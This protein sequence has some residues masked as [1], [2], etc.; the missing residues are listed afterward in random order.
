MII[1]TTKFLGAS[2]V[3]FS[4]SLGFNSNAST[5]SVTLVEDFENGDDF[6]ADEHSEANQ[7]AAAY[8]GTPFAKGNPGSYVKF[9]AP[10]GVF[11]FVGFVTNYRRTKSTSGNLINLEVSDGRFLLSQIPIINDTNLNINTTGFNTA[12]WNIFCAPA[13]FNNPVTI[14][15]NEKGIRFD[16]LM[17]ALS[18]RGFTFYGTTFKV[19]L[20]SSF[21]NQLIGGYRLK[22]QASTLDDAI[23]QAAREAGIDWYTSIES[24]GGQEVMYIKGINRKNQYV[25]SDQSN[26]ISNFISSNTATGVSSWEIGREL[27][28]EPTVTVIVGDRVRSLWDTS[29]GGTFNIF[30]ELGNGIVID[31][32]FVNLDFASTIGW[33]DYPTVEISLNNTVAAPSD[34][35][36]NDEYSNSRV[37]YQKITKSK[38]PK[39]RKGYIAT[40]T[41][42]RAALH[43]KEAW[44]TAV[45]YE[46]WNQKD[47]VAYNIPY[48][49]YN[50][51]DLGFGF[52]APTENE[53]LNFSMN[54]NKLGIY[55]P[56]FNFAEDN[57]FTSTATTS[58]P[59]ADPVAETAKEVAYQA[60]AR[61]AQEYYGKKFICR[62]PA[63]TICQDVG[64]QYEHN[65]KKIP[66]EYDIVDSAPHVT[67][68]TSNSFISFPNSLLN[69]DSAGFRSPNGLFK[70]FARFNANAIN[71]SYKYIR[72]N[73]FNPS[74]SV[75]AFSDVSENANSST[76]T[77]YYSG[78]SVEPYRFD[79]R[80]AIV[81]LNEPLT[82]GP[83][84][85][86]RVVPTSYNTNGEITGFTITTG[87]YTPITSN[88]KTGGFL[89][90]MSRVLG[91][92][93]IVSRTN[94]LGQ[95][96]PAGAGLVENGKEVPVS[97]Q[98]GRVS[99]DHY[100]KLQK[101]AVLY[102]DTVGLAEYR[103]SDLNTGGRG[104]FYIPLQWNYIK[105]GPWVN[106]GGS[107]DNN[108]RPVNIIED[109]KLNPWT[110]GSFS[111]M[112]DAANILAER[113]N[114][115]THTIGYATVT[116]AGF[117]Q[118][119]LG[120]SL[121]QGTSTIANVTNLTDI[122]VSY[123]TDGVKT[124]YKFKTFFGPNGFTKRAELDTISYN[125]YSTTNSQIGASEWQKVY[126]DNLE[127]YIRS[128]GGMRETNLFG[129]PTPDS[130]TKSS[131]AMT[132]TVGG[133]GPA[134]EIITGSKDQLKF[135]LEAN[136]WYSETASAGFNAVFI[137]VVTYPV[138]TVFNI[139]PTI[140][141]GKKQ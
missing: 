59:I 21:Y 105:Y 46:Y 64:L 39:S 69:A 63:S 38:V 73:Q 138:D 60:T 123:G 129:D 112:N 52:G 1:T 6:S 103:L 28:Q 42:L 124:T 141:G 83:G 70:A 82:C 19:I 53:S 40:E 3:S 50:A 29:G 17:F 136:P 12:S 110:Y 20:H 116:V 134:G 72:Y 25:F 33:L 18:Q 9:T 5:L 37:P 79:P 85:Y 96:D 57:P 122:N 88:D 139:C 95:F 80:F 43:S 15:W 55:G 135:T 76:S 87:N 68:Y 98:S 10:D 56:A 120:T 67:W 91:G 7:L 86:R 115:V 75:W 111:R 125:S 54:P 71:P 23:N 99:V 100:Y 26:G 77:L 31:R 119:N 47:Q 16:K 51:F 24:V 30:N 140:E 35:N 137:P 90:L 109:S 113:A 84:T 14:D 132:A 102:K 22:Q 13:V 93:Q 61:V 121:T 44:V 36:S 8:G 41:V 27:R 101:E 45:W 65:Q 128:Q 104:G 2:V 58:F 118:F 131:N 11:K 114:T 4:S 106:A 117:P 48:S 49:R 92:L 32:P 34:A 108:Q 66:I 94:G 62:L 107:A 89:E 78:V 126:E 127:K 97:W 81:T 133:S 74:N 130:A